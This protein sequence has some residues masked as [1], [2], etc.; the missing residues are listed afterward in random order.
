MSFSPPDNQYLT[1]FR[2]STSAVLITASEALFFCDFRYTEQAQEQVTGCEVRQVEGRLEAHVGEVLKDLG[3]TE[4]GFEPV[5]LS[6]DQ[7]ECVRGKMGG[8]LRPLRG[9]LSAL[10]QV[11]S[12]E[13]RDRIRA[14]S[15]LAEDALKE[16]LGGLEEGLLD[17]ELAA[18]LD[19]AF[20]RRGALKPSFDTIVLFGAASSL[21]HG[22]PHGKALERGD[23]VLVDCGCV[24]DGYCSDLT[25][26][27][28][29]GRIP[30]AWFEEIYAVT[31]AAQQAALD[32][33]A[34]GLGCGDADAA[35]REPIT[36]AGYGA[37]FGHGLGHGVGIEVHEAPRLNKTAEATLAAGMVVTVE[38]GIYLPDRGGVRIEDLV[39]IT[40]NGHDVLTR[41]PKELQVL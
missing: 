36:E 38:P 12:S 13:E 4:V 33:L 41:L 31:R 28:A 37:F 27:Y 34:P 14:A 40:E 7:A 21:P 29:Y 25:R 39:V 17:R 16:V 5:V 19:Y 20:K 15:E 6:M 24:L 30:G 26:T 2:G 35:A 18:R 11:K 3:V 1:G 9:V 10:R 22:M 32:S 8:E 23:I